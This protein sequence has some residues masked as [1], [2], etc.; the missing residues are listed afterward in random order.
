MFFMSTPDNIKERD[1]LDSK[2]NIFFAAIFT[3]KILPE[4]HYHFFILMAS[5]SFGQTEASLGSNKLEQLLVKFSEI[6]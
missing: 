4:F 2:M 3:W 6:F 1:F 5:Y